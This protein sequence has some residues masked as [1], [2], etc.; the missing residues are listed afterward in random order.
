M[1]WIRS[2]RWFR[3]VASAS[4]GVVAVVPGA[5]R[6][7]AASPPTVSVGDLAVVEGDSGTPRTLQVPISLSD[8][9]PGLVTVTYLVL[10]GSAS[11]GSDYSAKASGTAKFPVGERVKTLRVKILPDATAE[12]DETLTLALTAATGGVAVGRATGTVTILDDDPTGGLEVG[13]GDLAVVE[14]DSGTPRTV[15]VPVTLS[16]SHPA[17][18]TV[19]YVTSPVSAGAGDY[20]AKSSGTVKFAAGARVRAVNVRVLPETLA[21]ADETLTVTLTTTTAG[22]VTRSAGTVTILDDDTPAA[23]NLWAW[24]A[25]LYGQLGNGTNTGANTPVPVPPDTWDHVDAGDSHTCAVRDGS[26]WCWGWNAYGQLGN[27]T[28]TST[29]SPVPVGTATTWTQLSAGYR[30]SCGVRSDGTAWCWGDNT[31]GQL[32][33]GTNGASTVPVQVGTATNWV[34][35]AAAWY[36]TCGRR[37]DGTAWCWGENLYGQLGDGTTADSN[38]PVQVGTATTWTQVSAGWVHSCGARSDGTAWCWGDNTHGQLG[39]GTNTST[40]TPVA[41]AFTGGAIQ[42]SA[43]TG[44]SAAVD[45]PPP[46]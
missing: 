45:L 33:N 41:A 17:A 39:D 19:S 7:S 24:G 8:P 36:H 15:R 22:T 1:G 37:S 12:G 28:T 34:E 9:Q 29:N 23:A 26:A 44:H 6:V 10:P 31:F 43:G 40:N 30:H 46:S 4:L 38:V 13:V 20:Q 25:N 42:V 35:I 11:A 32:G 5:A 21:E 16:H 27:G 18:V 3:L 14:G 2:A